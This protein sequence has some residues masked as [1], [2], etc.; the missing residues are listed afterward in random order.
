MSLI[1]SPS[2]VAFLLAIIEIIY[3]A[4]IRTFFCSLFDIYRD[5]IPVRS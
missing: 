4:K 3:I 5:I 2:K 1:E